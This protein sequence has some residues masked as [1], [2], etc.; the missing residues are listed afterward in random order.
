MTTGYRKFHNKK[1]LAFGRTWDSNAELLYYVWL[2]QHPHVT[3]VEPQPA[4]WLLFKGGRHP[5]VGK[6]R[7]IRYVPDFRVVLHDG[8]VLIIDVKGK[9]TARDPV[10]AIKQKLMFS[11]C[12]EF[13]PLLAV[14]HRGRQHGYSYGVLAKGQLPYFAL[15][16]DE[17]IPL[18]LLEGI[19]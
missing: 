16:S 12:P 1:P 19:E 6:I 11:L 14:Y 17:I 18:R 5:H 15:H 3:S 13:F 7:D 4:S 2:R 8:T 9:P 10:Y